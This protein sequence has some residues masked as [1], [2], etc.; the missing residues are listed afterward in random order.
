MRQVSLYPLYFQK[1]ALGDVSPASPFPASPGKGSGLKMQEP[2]PF[3]GL[4]CRA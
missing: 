3:N 1:E 2:S 4:A